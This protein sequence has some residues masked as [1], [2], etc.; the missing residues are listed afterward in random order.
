MALI[1]VTLSE[2]SSIKSEVQGLSH[3]TENTRSKVAKIASNL[4]MQIKSRQ[5]IENRLARI[6]RDLQLQSEKLQSYSNVLNDVMNKFTE[7][8]SDSSIE[9][10][11]Q[12]SI[13]AFNKR[14]NRSDLIMPMPI[15]LLDQFIDSAADLAR[16]VNGESAADSSEVSFL[17]NIISWGKK[18][19]E[20]VVG[21]VKETFGNVVQAGKDCAS[22]MKEKYEERGFLYNA[23]NF[24]KGVLKVSGGVAAVSAAVATGGLLAPLAVTYGAND[25]VSGMGLIFDSTENQI[26]GAHEEIKEVNMLKNALTTVG[27]EVGADIGSVLGNEEYGRELGEKIGSAAYTTGDIVKN[28]Y[29]IDAAW[30]KIHQAK[31]FDLTGI[32]SEFKT[33]MGGLK[34]LATKVDVSELQYQFEL[35]KHTIPNTVNAVKN[36][37]MIGALGDALIGDVGSFTTEF[38]GDIISGDG[39]DIDKYSLFG[40]NSIVGGEVGKVRDIYNIFTK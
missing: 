33:T 10:I 39:I 19:V 8:D 2:L 12:Q 34:D 14:I 27:G 4:D 20:D 6:N 25:I 1:K 38:I 18:K 32:G 17:D 9:G 16:I 15:W 3:K 7:A 11:I 5:D 35:F 36:V 23:V 40:D 13:E 30:D 29:A 28:F 22:W 21:D 31:D 26:T 37:K 24:G